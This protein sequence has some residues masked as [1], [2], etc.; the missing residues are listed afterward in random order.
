MNEPESIITERKV[1]EGTKEDRR[2][3]NGMSVCWIHTTGHHFLIPD[4]SRDAALSS[5]TSPSAYGN[6]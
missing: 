4:V 6:L 1:S 3:D 2:E 5:S